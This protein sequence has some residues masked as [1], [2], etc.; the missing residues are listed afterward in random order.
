MCD[1][2]GRAELRRR[3]KLPRA[4]LADEMTEL[5]CLG[6]CLRF[7]GSGF[8]LAANSSPSPLAVTVLPSPVTMFCAPGANAAAPKEY[9]HDCGGALTQGTACRHRGHI[10]AI[11]GE[12]LSSMPMP[13][14]CGDL[15]QS[16]FRFGRVFFSFC[17]AV[18]RGS[19]WLPAPFE[20]LSKSN[21]RCAEIGLRRP[22]RYTFGRRQGQ[23]VGDRL[24]LIPLKA[25]SLAVRADRWP[26][27]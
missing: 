6:V 19:R 24:W 10:V 25:M 11:I 13:S 17:A 15:L 23:L 9:R 18:Q 7:D 2:V 8:V 5:A 14:P 1:R 3:R 26:A 27:P 21:P 4:Q 12:A 22:V 20:S 16:L